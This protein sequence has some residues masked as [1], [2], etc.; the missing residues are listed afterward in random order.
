MPETQKVLNTRIK[1]KI[2]TSAEWALA[3]TFV[4]LKGELI[5]YDD[6]NGEPA[7]FKFGDGETLVGELP[8][9]IDP[10]EAPTLDIDNTPTRYSSHLVTSNGI[11]NA[12]QTKYTLPAGGI[13]AT[14]LADE[15]KENIEKVAELPP[16]EYIPAVVKTGLASDLVNDAGFLNGEDTESADPVPINANTL[17]NHPASYFINVNMLPSRVVIMWSGAQNAIPSGW[18]LCDGT[19]NTPDLTS[20]FISNVLYYIMKQ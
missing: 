17:E 14:D 2:G 19:N 7:K 9:I 16:A 6:E 12:L 20:M 3:T 4:P 8:F 11:Y 18:L 10:I 1:H 5:I 13:P 15:V